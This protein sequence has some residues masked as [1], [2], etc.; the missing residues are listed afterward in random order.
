[1]HLDY[2]ALHETTD[3]VQHFEIA[4]VGGGLSGL[5]RA[6][7]LSENADP[8]LAIAIIDPA[9]G[10]MKEKTLSSWVK[11]SAPVHRYSSLVSHRWDKVQ[12][13]GPDGER[14]ERTLQNHLYEVIPGE[15]LFRHLQGKLLGDP[16]FTWIPTSV[17]SISDQPVGSPSTLYLESGE[18]I[19][20]N[21]ILASPVSPSAGLI[22]SF[23]G[24][25]VLTEDPCFHPDSVQLMDF[26]V[27][28]GGEVRFVY[29]LP[30]TEKHA[31]IEYTAFSKRGPE[32]SNLEARLMEWIETT[33]KIRSFQVLRLESGA[34]P[35]D[36]EHEPRFPP[37]F[38]SSAIESIGG[39]AGR[40]KPSTGYSFSRNLESPA[41]DSVS[42]L[43]K[44]RFHFY[45]R[46]LLG[47]VIRKEGRASEIF[48]ELFRN[49]PIDSVLSFLGERTTLFEEL[50]IFS[51]LPWLPFLTQLVVLRPFFIMIG[52][53]LGLQGLPG[54]WGVWLIPIL[55]LATIGMA[56]GG[57]DSVLA[58]PS[59]PKRFFSSYLGRILLNLAIWWITPPLALI[60]FLIQSADHFGEAEWLRVLRAS[61]NSAAVR[62]RAWLWGLFASLFGVFYHG[63]ESA[64]LIQALI[65]PS[66]VLDSITQADQRIIAYALLVLALWAA[67]S[68][69]RYHR[70]VYGNPGTGLPSTIG[71]AISLMVLPLLPG[72]FCYFAFWH[73]WDTMRV[74]MK[75]TKWTLKKYVGKSAPFTI[76]A[77]LSIVAMFWLCKEAHSRTQL[78]RIFFVAISALTAAHAPAMKRF[79]FS[80]PQKAPNAEP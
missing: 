32:D 59:T 77:H 16:R 63:D 58:S 22:Q 34:V 78:L 74:Q 23:V 9:P 5:I 38:L 31:L 26:S 33:L 65:G 15:A 20:A 67:R 68:L 79:L 36:A 13:T 2:P 57:L 11:K 1:M 10:K 51:R 19:T 17:R 14:L 72:F 6:D 25:E 64:P 53:T 48:F 61:G 62:L 29:L 12:I 35:M 4:I 49:H 18:S 52:L 70:R 44:I 71:L 76:L 41:P 21:R 80:D 50:K 30:F 46:L 56:H 66:Q 73:G 24:V 43:R 27:P 42:L 75:T 54:A 55:G 39:A 3:P 45:D 8:N 40:I 69:D 60:L 7:L 47:V 37:S 28:Q